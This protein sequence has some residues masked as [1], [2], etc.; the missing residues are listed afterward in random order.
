MF[1]SISSTFAVKT[2]FLDLISAPYPYTPSLSPL[3]VIPATFLKTETYG[4]PVNVTATLLTFFTVFITDPSHL[5]STA[6]ISDEPSNVP[7]HPKLVLNSS[8]TVIVPSIIL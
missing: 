1:P 7:I 3:L 6:D 5:F 4:C 2:I 8:S